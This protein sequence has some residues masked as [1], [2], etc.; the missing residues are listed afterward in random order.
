MKIIVD[1]PN[2]VGK[3]SLIEGIN[4]YLSYDIIH[5]SDHLEAS[6]DYF[7]IIL[8]KS[9]IILDR[10][11]ISELVYSEIYN[12][13]SNLKSYEVNKLIDTL[14]KDDLYVVLLANKKVLHR[15]YK[16]KGEADFSENNDKFIDK[17][18]KLFTKYSLQFNC[19]VVDDYDFDKRDLII[20]SIFKT[21]NGD[22]KK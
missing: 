5:C 13:P 2:N 4:K 14:T 3:S 12:R 11:P 8:N 15:N 21:L 6:Y 9:N 10:G 17:E 19:F 7:N 22:K 16:L 1:G 20:N 18:L